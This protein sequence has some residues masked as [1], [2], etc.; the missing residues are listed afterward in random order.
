MNR[1][2]LIVLII[3]LIAVPAF[4]NPNEPN[5]IIP[6]FSYLTFYGTDSEEITSDETTSDETTSE[7][8]TSDEITS[9]EIIAEKTI[10]ELMIEAEEALI[11]ISEENAQRIVIIEEEIEIP[12]ALRNNVYYLESLRLKKLAQDTFEYG[13]YDASAS[14]AE[15]AILYAEL[16]DEYVASQLIAE[17]KR[18]IGWADA[19]R[20]QTRYPID[21]TESKT[22]YDISVI[23]NT[24]EE[25]DIAI[26]N[27]SRAIR[28]LAM[29][30]AGGTG[31]FASSSGVLP[32]QYTVRT[33]ASVRDCFWNIAGYAWVYGDPWK[34]RILYEANKTKLP[35]PNNPNIVEPGTILDIPS[36]RGE[37]RQGM[38]QPNR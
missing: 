11:E 19:N 27:A 22:Y 12:E 9:D 29:L 38:W 4:S 7:E 36:I 31:S 10:E 8:I 6:D 26:E 35:N 3:S 24:N 17:A 5:L 33:W 1:K 21:Y 30:E 14:F 15:E 13:D 28:I 16:S 18:L 23:A 34:W 32:N 20:I 25:W 37:I 2:I